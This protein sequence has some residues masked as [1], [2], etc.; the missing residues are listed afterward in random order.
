MFTIYEVDDN[1]A[2]VEDD[3]NIQLTTITAEKYFT[4]RLF[5][6]GKKYT[7]EIVN[8]DKQSDR[9]KLSG[10][11]SFNKKLHVKIKERMTSF[12]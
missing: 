8:K 3:G 11:T 7:R 9:D 4:L 6:Y 1:D 12:L 5:N 2:V 10:L